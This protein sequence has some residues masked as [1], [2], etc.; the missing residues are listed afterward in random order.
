MLNNIFRSVSNNIALEQL[1]TDQVAETLRAGKQQAIIQD[2]QA[3]LERLRA[4]Q[5]PS[6]VS[7]DSDY[8]LAVAL[9]QLNEARTEALATQRELRVAHNAMREMRPAKETP[10][11]DS[12]VKKL[13]AELAQLA[14][15]KLDADASILELMLSSESFKSITKK[16][17]KELGKCDEEF[18]QELNQAVVDVAETDPQFKISEGYARARKGL[19]IGE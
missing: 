10:E 17:A 3:E 12:L 11:T 18:Q 7:S 2:Q 1:K 6:F 19:E 15:A 4:S 13:R 16:Y 9:R 14:L 5:A 8:D